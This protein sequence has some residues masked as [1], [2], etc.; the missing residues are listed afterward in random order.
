MAAEELTD[1][2]LRLSLMSPCYTC[3]RLSRHHVALRLIAN[4]ANF[5]LHVY[6]AMMKLC[7]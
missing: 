5:G 7:L 1:Q 6:Q 2:T 4:T 3:N